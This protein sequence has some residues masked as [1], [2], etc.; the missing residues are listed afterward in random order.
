[1]TKVTTATLLLTAGYSGAVYYALNNEAFHDT[2]TTYVP[3]GEQVLDYI[4]E[5]QNNK[6]LQEYRQK[7]RDLTKQASEYANTAKD[8]SIKAKDATVDAYEYASD[9]IAKLT[10]QSEGAVA[11]TPGAPAPVKKKGTESLFGSAKSLYTQMMN[12]R[13]NLPKSLLN[14][15]RLTKYNQMSPQLF[16]FQLSLVN[17]PIF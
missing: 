16:N 4:D 7:A 8:Y 1:V 2:F 14:S 12:P 15:S 11:P 10:G 9:T 3:G 17:W 13:A 5:F 6:D